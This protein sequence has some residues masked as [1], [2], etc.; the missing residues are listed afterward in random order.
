MPKHAPAGM[1]RR[2]AMS[3]LAVLFALLLT[4]CA[5]TS[6]PGPSAGATSG[7][8]LRMEYLNLAADG[9]ALLAFVPQKSRIRVFA[10]RGGRAAR[11]GHNH[12]VSIDRGTG[13][14]L[15]PAGHVAN[16]R[17]DLAFRLDEMHFDEAVDR[18]ALGGAFASR[19]APDDID[20]TRANFLGAQS[21]QAQAY[22]EVRIHSLRVVGEMPRIAA[23]LRIEM[24]GTSKQT[25]V[26]LDVRGDD[27]HIEAK[28]ALVVEQSDFGIKPYSVFGG[29]LAVEDP[30]V[31]EFALVGEAL[32][33]RAP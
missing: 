32:A 33:L 14:L 30:L 2:Q 20:R 5:A 7:A 23:Q 31:V 16:A 26:A 8:D 29:L 24:H 27:R 17:F 11:L 1:P 19:L 3:A 15:L 9:D 18:E 10:F 25:W 21:A 6:V 13:Y 4:G 12:V 28:G 22:P